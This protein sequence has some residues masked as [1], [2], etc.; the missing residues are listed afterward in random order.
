MIK[1]I[2]KN[3]KNRVLTII[4]SIFIILS[5][6]LAGIFSAQA[7]E[8]GI[9][10]EG[11]NS[12]S[13][14]DPE[15][16]MEGALKLLIENDGLKQ[17]MLNYIK[18][19]KIN[20]IE[21]TAVREKMKSMMQDE[22]LLNDI[23][24]SKYIIG[25]NCRDAYNSIVSASTQVGKMN[26]DICFDSERLSKLYVGLDDEDVMIKLASLAFH[27]HTHHFQVHSSTKKGIEKNEAEA[28]LISGYISITA[29]FVQL[30]LLKWTIPSSGPEEFQAIQN[31]YNEIKAKEQAFIAPHS[32]D[33]ALYPEYR[34][35]LDKGVI[36]L[37]PREKYDGKISIRGGGAYYSFKNLTHDYG[38]SSD[39]E[40][41]GKSLSVGF[42][43]CDFGYISDLGNVPLTSVTLDSPSL[44]FLVDFKVAKREPQIRVQQLDT[45]TGVVKLAAGKYYTFKGR[46]EDAKV[47]HTYVLRSINFDNSDVIV[48]FRIIRFDTDGSMIFAWK[49]LKEFPISS[50]RD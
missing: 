23:K 4:L 10:I 26:S 29:K 25:S 45:R 14:G 9:L 28:N 12:T 38:Y 2:I 35:E 27:E 8:G 15:K 6:S 49:K 3:I 13:G 31:L 32:N 5:L 46:I 42:A 47:G 44:S 34:G 36:R 39:I 7:D 22:S 16:V 11:G 40:L 19:I 43:G 48:V 41:Q 50:C 20:Q 33:Y 18:T 1:T 37:L 24:N 21:D 30:P 17:A